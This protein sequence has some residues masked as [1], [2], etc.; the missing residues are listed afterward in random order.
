MSM[1][2]AGLEKA[3]SSKEDQNKVVLKAKEV[4]STLLAP[5]RQAIHLLAG[6]G[7]LFP[8]CKEV[9]KS[10]AVRVSSPSWD[11]GSHLHTA[12]SDADQA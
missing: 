4:A 1:A 7:V 8:P 2:R 10:L 3:R 5:G 12:Y 6:H 11:M 9:S